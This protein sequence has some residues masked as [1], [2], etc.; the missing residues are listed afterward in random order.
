MQRVPQVLS[1]LQT[2]HTMLVDLLK[3]RL[4]SLC[5]VNHFVSAY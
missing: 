3:A 1:H 5:Y 4:F 2:L